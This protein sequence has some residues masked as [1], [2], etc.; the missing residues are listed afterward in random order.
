MVPPYRFGCSF[1]KAESAFSRC[2]STCRRA[3]G[4]F[5]M[6]VIGLISVCT[7]CCY[8]ATNTVR[9]LSEESFTLDFDLQGPGPNSHRSSCCK[10]S[11]RVDISS[12]IMNKINQPKEPFGSKV[13]PILSVVPRPSPGTT[14]G[15]DLRSPLSVFDASREVE[16]IRRIEAQ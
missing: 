14:S 13:K 4:R 7:P 16:I 10:G 5:S 2:T 9:F 15:D 1:V 12:Q 11:P 3:T 6:D 8:D